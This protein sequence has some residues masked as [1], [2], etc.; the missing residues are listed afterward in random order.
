MASDLR[1]RI[2]R[3]RT[4]KHHADDHRE[5]DER[6]GQPKCALVRILLRA[7]TRRRCARPKTGSVERIFAKEERVETDQRVSGDD[8]LRRWVLTL[9]AKEGLWPEATRVRELREDDEPNVVS[10]D[11]TGLAKPSEA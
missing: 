11:P 10:E 7:N 6:D 8:D 9:A 3:E 4:A 1:A 2:S 5:K